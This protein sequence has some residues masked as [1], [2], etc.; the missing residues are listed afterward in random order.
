VLDLDLE[1]SIV[2]PYV[3]DEAFEA[4]DQADVWTQ[5]EWNEW[6]AEQEANYDC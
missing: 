3:S 1:P 5:Q 2:I 4:P 6:K